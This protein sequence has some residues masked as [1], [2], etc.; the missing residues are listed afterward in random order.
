MKCPNESSKFIQ[1]LR[2][3]KDVN[4]TQINQ[5]LIQ[6]ETQEF[7]DWFGYSKTDKDGKVGY[8]TYDYPRLLN[9]LYIVNKTGDQISL[10]D[11]QNTER[12]EK[13][14]KVYKKINKLKEIE[15]AVK[16]Q[17]ISLHRRISAYSHTEYAEN[18]KTLID[19]IKKVDKNDE[20]GALA[21]YTINIL[22]HLDKFENRLYKYENTNTEN[23]SDEELKQREED[24]FN[25]LLQAKQFTLTYGDITKL[26]NLEGDSN[27]AIILQDL[28]DSEARVSDLSSTLEKE[29]DRIWSTR[30]KEMTT[31]PQIISGVIDF[32]GAQDDETGG[33]RWLDALSDSHH[34]VLATLGKKYNRQL[35]FADLNTKRLTKEWLKFCEENNLKTEAD[36]KKF[37]DNNGKFLE[38]YDYSAYYEAMKEAKEP[39]QKVEDE[40]RRYKEDGETHTNE[41]VNAKHKYYT[42]RDS[43]TISNDGYKT[44]LPSNKYKNEKYNKLTK[45]ELEQL[46]YIQKF[47]FELIKHTNKPN[48]ITKGFFPAIANTKNK[49]KNKTDNVEKAITEA[50][51]VVKFIPFEFIKKL[52]Q[53]ELPKILDSMTDEEKTKVEDEITLIKKQNKLNHADAINYNLYEVMGHFIKAAS[54]NRFKTEMHLDVQATVSQFKLL[55]IK[56]KTAQGN[57]IVDKIASTVK[58]TKVEHEKD[59]IDSNAYKHLLDWVE[60]VFY[61]E[62]NLDEGALSEWGDTINV[63]TSMLGI[64]FKPLTAI[65]NKIV[66]NIQLAMEAAG[67]QYFNGKELIKARKQYFDVIMNVVSEHKSKKS[68]TITTGLIKYF[69]ILQ[70]HDELPN[71]AKGKAALLLH[72][73]KLINEAAYFMLHI[74]EHQIQNTTLIALLHSHKIINGKVTS[75][76][77]Y[78]KQFDTSAEVKK[79]VEENKSKEEIHTYINANK[80]DEKVK[81]LEFDAYPAMID[82]FE[83]I[84]GAIELKKD[85]ILTDTQIVDFKNF[86]IGMNQKLQGIYNPEDAGM[87]QR[88]ILGRLGMKFRKW[89]PNQWNRRFGQKFGKT[90]YNERRE[91]DEEG[92]Y[93]STY[94]YISKP[95]TTSYKEYRE[96]QINVAMS[97]FKAIFYGLKDL[98]VNAKI[99]W[100][101]L[102]PMQKANIKRTALEMTILVGAI[103]IGSLLKGG[104]DDDDKEKKN[105]LV[106]LGLYECDR[107]YGELTTFTPWGVLREGNK[108]FDNPSAAFRTFDGVSKVLWNTVMYPIRDEEETKFKSGI[109]HGQDKASKY[110][111]DILPVINS[112][113]QI[114]YLDELNKQNINR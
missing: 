104:D 87:I 20:A 33:Q 39:M 65:N 107:L 36:F 62:F 82:Q 42:W 90:S 59:A 76:A 21:L 23:L 56:Q 80:I 77:T 52:N 79:M 64:G 73:T 6:L 81:R 49:I 38:E 9:N 12:F 50:G 100:A 7:Q 16:I 63:A 4:N 45:N 24:Y 110:L 75:F 92:M 54:I 66:G 10:F 61:E 28:R 55:K 22:E 98:F 72:K 85:S 94:K 111:M 48:I 71:T 8:D 46:D 96:Q 31:N 102:N 41:Y 114:E 101:V 37:V 89:I 5:I 97:A 78:L 18:I 109:Y 35:G 25:F 30:L 74:G 3:K 44:F 1:D 19:L 53:T 17:L 2:A 15:E 67:N 84:D 57:N 103:L 60:G 43:N 105:M 34:P 99:N 51:E 11:L 86:V 88:H 40:G 93:I 32:L 47:L 113:Q 26:P 69:D 112:I 106:N 29:I 95:F 13:A 27:L 83:L 68:N 14:S 58:G 91:A 70:E 108:L